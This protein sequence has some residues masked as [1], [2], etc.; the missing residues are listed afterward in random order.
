MRATG[1]GRGQ[2]P[3]WEQSPPFGEPASSVPCTVILR[4]RRLLCMRLQRSWSFEV[5][6]PVRLESSVRLT[7]TRSLFSLTHVMSS[8]SRRSSSVLRRG[9]PTLL[10]ISSRSFSPRR[11]ISIAF[12]LDS[13][14]FFFFSSISYHL[15]TLYHPVS[16]L[17]VV[18]RFLPV[19]RA[20]V[21][22]PILCFPALHGVLT[23]YGEGRA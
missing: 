6:T 11:Y 18:T 10:A 19:S 17:R 14:F 3:E 9:L 7:L 13:V 21:A 23:V 4:R 1:R 12:A 5:G 16:E 22:N 2:L 8:T 15:S 20:G